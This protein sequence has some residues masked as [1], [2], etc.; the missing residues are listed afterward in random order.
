MDD[1]RWND[2]KVFMLKVD[3]YQRGKSDGRSQSPHST[4]EIRTTQPYGG[5]GGRK[6]EV[7]R[8]N[9]SKQSFGVTM[10]SK[11][12]TETQSRPREDRWKWVEEN[13]WSDNMLTA[14]VNGVKGNKWFS[15][16]DKVYKPETLANAWEKVKA[17]KGAGGIDNM[18][19]KIFQANKGRYLQELE[20]Q[21]KLG[22]YQPDAVKRVY[23][24]KG[25]GKKRPLGIPTVKDRIVQM[26]IKMVIEPI[27]EKE[28]V[29]D[30][31][32]FRPGKGQKDAL[33]TVDQLIK[34]GY[35]WVVDADLKSY[36]DTIPHENLMKDV[37]E[38]ISDGRI[39]KLIK[40][41]L[42]QE[43][44]DEMKSWIPITGTPQGAVLSPLLANVYLH[45]LDCLMRGLNYKMVRYA[46][47]FVIL[48][49][50]EQEA[51]QALARVRQWTDDRGLCL[52]PEKTHVGN[53]MKEGEGF[54]FLGY[55]FEAG[56]RYVRKKSFMKFKEAIRTKTSRS[57]GISIQKVIENL[58]PLL[59][60][61][62][63]YFKQAYK[64]TFPYVDGFIRRRLRAILRAQEKRQAFG[65]TKEDHKRWPNKYFANLGLFTMETHRANEVACQSRC[66]NY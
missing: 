25:D 62:Y 53:C 7:G 16:I 41:F 38:R 24:P 19:I 11:Q 45:P 52:H 22:S 14:L 64:T 46:D 4:D 49:S 37:E 57:C 26:A 28:F 50:S 66:G 10:E 48:C 58:N 6:I 1:W 29:S 23:I 36:F 3:T 39:L 12:E 63:N 55:R 17:K 35:C 61:W 44:M 2:R 18:T 31:Y 54:E 15:L 60:G 20:Q 65:R 21:L 9:D 30:S 59:K 5:K 32:G 47:D 27:F 8:T 33:R 43:I 13:I 42:N 34:E 40:L 56:R 51:E